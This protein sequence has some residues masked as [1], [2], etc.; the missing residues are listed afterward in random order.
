MGWFA[1]RPRD[2]GS[3]DE[4]ELGYRLRRSVWGKGYGTEGSL[5]LIH[6][7]FTQLGMQRVFATTMCVME[8]A[9]LTLVRTFHLDWPEAI[10]GGELGDVEYALDRADWQRQQSAPI[11]SGGAGQ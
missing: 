2:D 8:K 7:G 9:G 6:M 10:E 11:V 3:P 1:L 5:A 4:A